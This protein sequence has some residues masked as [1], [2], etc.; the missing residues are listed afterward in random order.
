MVWGSRAILARRDGVA[1]VRL[2]IRVV[3]LTLDFPATCPQSNA[4]I[5]GQIVGHSIDENDIPRRQSDP[6]HPAGSTRRRRVVPAPGA[7]CPIRIAARPALTGRAASL[8]SCA[9]VLTQIWRHA[10]GARMHLPQRVRH[11]DVTTGIEQGSGKAI[12]P[13]GGSSSRIANAELLLRIPSGILLAHCAPVWW[14]VSRRTS[15]M[16]LAFHR[17]NC[18]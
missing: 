12:H 3:N 8:T 16:E 4:T 5:W 9:A 11:D 13:C 17:G 14:P 2:L 1:G 10:A 6:S 18:P 7:N 15:L